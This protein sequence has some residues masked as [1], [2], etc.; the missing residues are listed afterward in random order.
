MCV[1]VCACVCVRACVCAC[2]YDC[3]QITFDHVTNTCSVCHFP[4]N[5]QIEQI[6]ERESS[7]MA[8]DE[9]QMVKVARKK[10]VVFQLEKLLSM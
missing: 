4:D 3:C 5:H 9:D 6:E 2:A 8:L 10:D 7:G 1:C